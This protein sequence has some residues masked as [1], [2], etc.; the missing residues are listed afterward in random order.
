MFLVFLNNVRFCFFDCVVLFFLMGEDKFNFL[1]FLGWG[2]GRGWYL[3]GVNLRRVGKNGDEEMY[4]EM[5]IGSR[6]GLILWCIVS[7]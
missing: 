4:E 6:G 5:E 3:M 2:R 1:M 7:K